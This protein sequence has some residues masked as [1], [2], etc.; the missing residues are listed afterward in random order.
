M[1]IAIVD[2]SRLAR[3]ELKQQIANLN[4]QSDTAKY[5]I[6]SEA[7]NVKEALAL[8]NKHHIDLLL[9]DIDLPDGNGFDVLEQASKVPQTIFV[10]A[11]DEYAIKSFEYNA[12]DYLMKPVRQNRLEQA[13]NKVKNKRAQNKLTPENRIFIKDRDQCFFVSIEDVYAFEALGNYTKVH[14]NNAA[15]C[16]YRPISNIHERL[17]AKLFFKASR[18]WLVNTHFINKIEAM[19]N[20]SFCVR[21]QNGLELVISKRQAAQFKR[22]WSL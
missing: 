4:E 11:Y 14:L 19:E 20:G 7:A 1:R 9:L 6:V 8:L 16:V 22:E 3:L 21:M 5:E 10:S 13:L 18:S 12:L 17:D 2:D 15:P